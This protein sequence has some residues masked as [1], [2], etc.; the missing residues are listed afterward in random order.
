M[1]QNPDE[2]RED[3]ERTRSELSQ[4]V[5]ALSEKVSPSKVAHR[6]TEKVRD[7]V[8]GW[9]DKVMGT[10]NDATSRVSEGAEHLADSTHQVPQQ[11]KEKTR[12][13]P[14]A[15]GLIALGAG[16]LVASLLPASEAERKAAA[17]L[18]DQA[19][20]LVDDAKSQAQSMAEE[21]KQP[22]QESVQRVKESAT[23]SA[24]TLKSEGQSQTEHVSD[25]ARSSAEEVRGG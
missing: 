7:T 20:P 10:A 4:D 3:I 16:W 11:T 12:G 14:L 21:M 5:D 9:K 6:Q 19:Q 2:I 18:E 8:T 15:A 1:T 24:E 23:D 22:A 13:N 17:K 25:A